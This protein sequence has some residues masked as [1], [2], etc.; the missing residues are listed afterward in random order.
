M[1]HDFFGKKLSL[2]IQISYNLHFDFTISSRPQFFVESP[3][4]DRRLCHEGPEMKNGIKGLILAILCLVGSVCS[5]K[6]V[7]CYF[8]SWSTYRF[9]FLIEIQPNLSTNFN[10]MSKLYC[11]VKEISNLKNTQEWEGKV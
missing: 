5:Q 10:W 1:N 4:I 9:V 8:G 7:Y 2:E 11:L 3:V 6:Y